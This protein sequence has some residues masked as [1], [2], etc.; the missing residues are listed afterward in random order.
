MADPDATWTVARTSP[1]RAGAREDGPAL[2]SGAEAPRRGFGQGFPGREEDLVIAPG[3]ERPKERLEGSPSP[4]ICNP[5]GH[6]ENTTA[7]KELLQ[8]QVVMGESLKKLGN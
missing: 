7:R 5:D 6:R 1:R 4:L 3:A 2:G 8:V